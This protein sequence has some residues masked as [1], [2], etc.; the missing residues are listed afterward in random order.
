MLED[1]KEIIL[2]ALELLKEEHYNLA[3]KSRTMTARKF[4]VNKASEVN[5]VIA[6]VSAG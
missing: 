2:E 4:L 6:R 3:N 5:E 1:D